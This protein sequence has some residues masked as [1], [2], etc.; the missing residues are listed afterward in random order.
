MVVPSGTASL[1]DIQ[2]TFGGSHPISLSEYYSRPFN[3][4]GSSPANGTISIN[5][6]RGKSPY[7]AASPPSGY[8]APP[9]APAPPN[10]S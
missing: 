10:S 1:Q 4:G 9:P 2:N 5:T 3:Q 8:Y 7:V 6:F